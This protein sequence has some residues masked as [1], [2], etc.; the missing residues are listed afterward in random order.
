M[1]GVSTTG[2]SSF[3][4]AFVVGRKRVPSP[5]AGTMAVLMPLAE[6]EPGSELTAV[7]GAMDSQPNLMSWPGLGVIA[8]K[9]PP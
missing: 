9:Q 2:S 8:N 1:P 3:G 6:A 5:A 4:T 7:D